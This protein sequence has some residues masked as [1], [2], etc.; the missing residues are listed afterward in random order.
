MD[1]NSKSVKVTA[2]AVVSGKEEIGVVTRVVDSDRI[3]VAIPVSVPAKIGS[4]GPSFGPARSYNPVQLLL[5]NYSSYKRSGEPA[6]FMRYVEESWVNVEPEVFEAV[7]VGFLK[8]VSSVET[9]IGGSKCLFDLHRMI[10]LNLGTGDF[11]SV[12]WIDVKGMCFFPKSFVCSRDGG[13]ELVNLGKD[14]KNEVVGNANE[15]RC[16]VQP[17]LEIEIKFTEDLE[18]ESNNLNDNEAKLNKRKREVIEPEGSTPNLEA[19][20]KHVEESEFVSP[21]WPK[22]RMLSEKEIGYRIV[23]NLFVQGMAAEGPGAVI[24][25]IH[26]RVRKDGSMERAEYDAFQ[27]QI[28]IVSQAR[29]NTDIVFAWLGTTANEVQNIM[30]HGIGAAGMA[31]SSGSL[32]VGLYLSPARS[33]R[34]RY[35]V[36]V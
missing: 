24:T 13:N 3:A 34:M 5:Q 32:G 4:V 35:A 9:E 21:R 15:S 20:R 11:R 23:R 6:R 31:S 26:Q 19:K 18:N 1:L 17:K 2:K 28:E 33:P 36:F 27:K 22:T 14:E 25:A 29:G 16:S 7:K 8:G 30:T 10:E 12:A